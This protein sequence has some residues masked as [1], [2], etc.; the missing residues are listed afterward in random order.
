MLV[1]LGVFE[2]D[3]IKHDF[4]FNRLLSNTVKGGYVE[5]RPTGLYEIADPLLYQA[6]KDGL[7]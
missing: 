4:T 1:R 2:A 3:I 5:K 6:A 7:L